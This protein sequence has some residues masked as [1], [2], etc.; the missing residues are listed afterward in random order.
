M[1]WWFVSTSERLDK[2][3]AQVKALDEAVKRILAA[4]EAA[5]KKE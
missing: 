4:L 3:E 5:A 2:L 1:W